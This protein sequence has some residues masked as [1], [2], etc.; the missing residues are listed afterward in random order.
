M[1]TSSPQPLPQAPLD[2][3]R[4]L[5]LDLDGTALDERGRLSPALL[6]A[7]RALRGRVAYTFVTAR[8]PRM[9]QVYCAQAG[10]SGPVITLDGG[11][12]LDWNSRRKLACRPIEPDTALFL[13]QLCHRLGLEFTFYTA[14]SGYF[15]RNTGRLDRFLQF[16]CQ[17]AAMGLPPMPCLFYEA[18]SPQELAREGI[19]RIDIKKPREEG[20]C[21][22]LMEQL[23]ACPQLRAAASGHS[24]LSI[25][26]RQAGKGAAAEFLRSYLGL[27]RE[28]ICAFGDH[29]NDVDMFQASGCP[30]A[31]GNAPRGVQQK[32]RYVTLP[33][34][35]D[36]VAWF[37]NQFLPRAEA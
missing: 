29:W 30:V 36:G 32:A 12:V 34:T 20:T 1:K 26:H 23:N 4:L 16:N 31:M 37:L 17:A 22:A 7:L 14:Q 28:E 8:S 27:E 5:L 6:V 25:T 21:S 13:M 11:L 10:I 24:S 3:V 2:R 9:I 18:Y 33:N 15:P 19:L 35:Q